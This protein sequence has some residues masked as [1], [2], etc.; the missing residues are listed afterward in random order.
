LIP[1]AAASA[2]RNSAD[3]AELSSSTQARFS[4]D[5]PPWKIRPNITMKISGK[6]SVQNRAARSRV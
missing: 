3:C 5:S 4:R 6:A 2:V 1:D